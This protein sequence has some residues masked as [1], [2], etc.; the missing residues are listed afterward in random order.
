VPN[1]QNPTGNLMSRARRGALLD[2]A[3]R[4]DVLIVEDDPYGSLYFDDVATADDSR[5]IKADDREGR[6][7]YLS[8]FSKT[9]APGF[10]VAWIAAPPAAIAKLEIAK[11][12]ADLCTGGLDQRMVFEMWRRGTVTARL[13]LLRAT[14][15]RK[16]T[17]LE[18]ALRRELPHDV[19]WPEPKGGFFL[20]A[21]FADQVDTDALLPRAIE[22]GIVFVPGSAFFVEGSGA[23]FAR[24]AFSWAT[25]ER[26]EEGI[27]RLAA[28][29][30]ETKS[31][32]GSERQASRS[33]LEAG[34][35][36]SKAVP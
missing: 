9:V 3:A 26:I 30:R 4:R 24:L 15:Q 36:A 16:R 28:V 10:R 27:R 13:P 5:P 31:V 8:S 7:V 29:V 14:Y 1:F 2:W 25:P 35:A 33:A 6:V 17:V 22:R 34:S 32:S 12:S 23:R 21:C 18:E 11:Q 19:S 20:W